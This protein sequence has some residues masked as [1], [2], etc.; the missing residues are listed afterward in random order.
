LRRSWV[1]LAISLAT[2]AL[3]IVVARGVDW[4]KT[5]AAVRG[6][7]PALLAF[8]AMANLATLVIKAIRWSLFLR[9]TGARGLGFVIRA[10]LAG[11]ALNSV[12]VANGGD[13]ARVAAVSRHTGVSSAA[14]LGTLA[15][16]RLS[17]LATYVFLFAVSA[18]VLPL[19][20]E[21][22]RW[23]GPGAAALGAL[24]VI[25]AAFVA[26]G[27]RAEANR[28]SMVASKVTFHTRARDY[29]RLLAATSARIATP[30]RVAAA[31]LLALLAWVGQW[32]TFHYTARATDL[33]VTPSLSLLAL[34]VVNASF[35]VRLTPGNLGVFQLLYALAVTSAGVDRDAAVATAFLITAIQYIPVVLIGL[36]LAP[37]LA[38]G[39][40]V[41]E[42]V[43]PVA[44]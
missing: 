14:I 4:T 35:L 28:E 17:D 38:R 7:D 15:V 37:S 21:L 43:G 19:P 36:P 44:G 12:V 2:A 20:A 39:R 30:G 25:C 18:F 5:W 13:A 29:F 23:R 3:L 27:R 9:A 8:A 16:D 10:T 32:A 11:A 22:S 42:A 41:A 40:H 26:W 34:I 33:G 6:A 31:L 1:H 24:I